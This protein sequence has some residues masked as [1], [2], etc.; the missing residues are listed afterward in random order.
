MRDTLLASVYYSD[1]SFVRIGHLPS[2]QN[3]G[4]VEFSIPGRSG[5]LTATAYYVEY[6]DST[7]YLWFGTIADHE[8]GYLMLV[9]ETYGTAGFIQTVDEFYTLFPVQFEYALMFEHAIGPWNTLT[10]GNTADDTTTVSSQQVDICA[11]PVD[12]CPAVIDVLVLIS[13]PA[14][15]WLDQ[16]RFL[17][18]IG[19]WPPQFVTRDLSPLILRTIE[20]STN[21]ALMLSNVPNKRFRFRNEDFEFDFDNDMEIRVD[22][23]NLANGTEGNAPERRNATRSDIVVMYTDQGYDVAGAAFGGPNMNFAYAITEIRFSLAPRWTFAHE[24]AHLFGAR[25]NRS[26]NVPCNNCPGSDNTNNCAH[27][28]RFVGQDYIERRTI[29]AASTAINVNNPQRRILH[30]SSPDV[31]VA[32]TATG[33]QDDDNARVFRNAGCTIADFFA[34]PGFNAFISSHYASCPGVLVGMGAII[35][36][37]AQ[38][39]PGT[40]PYTFEWRW[41]TTGLFHPL[42][43]GTLIGYD[44]NETFVYPSDVTQVFLQLQIF[45]A[46]NLTFVYTHRIGTIP[47]EHCPIPLV[48]SPTG[49]LTNEGT[50]ALHVFPNPSDGSDV[51][52]SYTGDATNEYVR[53]SLINALGQVIEYGLCM[54]D[55]SVNHLIALPAG[56]Y[57]LLLHEPSG[58]Q[59]NKIVVLD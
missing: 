47:P 30:F 33:T 4:Q 15:A 40:G 12:D 21:V 57:Y 39:F 49:H 23:P 14:R 3:K 46:D 51:R 22:L 16:F 45:T 52:F 35:Q 55:G 28:W 20:T 18:N 7:N 13:E 11:E 31:F 50:S 54:P 44:Q 8:P 6:T 1:Y 5:T 27:G 48:A 53:Y 10:C 29:M 17:Q 2:L 43:P 19:G 26:A 32:G 9:R 59:V 25:H 38:G 36:P 56:Y 58:S 42:D 34:D 41:N 24:M 37:P